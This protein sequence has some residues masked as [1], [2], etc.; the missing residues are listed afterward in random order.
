MNRIIKI[1]IADNHPLFR[2]GVISCVDKSQSNIE[3]CGEAGNTDELF[4]LLK[5][6][7]VDVLLLNMH[8]EGESNNNVIEK[9]NRDFKNVHV[10][11]I[12]DVFNRSNISRLRAMNIKGFVSKDAPGFEMCTAIQYVA[13][14]DE[15]MNRSLTET[16]KGLRKMSA[17]QGNKRFT[18]REIE[19]I[20]L[21][22]EGFPVREIASKLNISMKT[23]VAHKYN[24][25][26]KLNIHSTNE[27]MR[28]A[29]KNDFVKL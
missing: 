8:L 4:S 29:I 12:S 10:L 19:I 15:F 27:L 22:G 7:Q 18:Q 20:A 3:V 6:E 21:C 16:V 9:L 5:Q 2:Q 11:I 17:T 13:D 23:V 28:Y 1:L 14:G 26:S 25:F 24:I